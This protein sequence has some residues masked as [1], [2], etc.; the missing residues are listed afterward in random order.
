LFSSE[1]FKLARF[2]EPGVAFHRGGRYP[3]VATTLAEVPLNIT[4]AHLA[5]TPL[6]LVLSRPFV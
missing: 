2:S 3:C 1:N 5:H 6:P 4:C